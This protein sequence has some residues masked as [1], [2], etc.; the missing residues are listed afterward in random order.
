MATTCLTC[1]DEGIGSGL[2]GP[3][4]G[5]PC[6]P[7]GS[8]HPSCS[9]SSFYLVWLWQ[10]RGPVEPPWLPLSL[11]SSFI[12]KQEI[13]TVKAKLAV[14]VPCPHWGKPEAIVSQ[15]PLKDH[16]DIFQFTTSRLWSASNPGNSKIVICNSQDPWNYVNKCIKISYEAFQMYA[17]VSMG[18]WYRGHGWWEWETQ[19]K[20]KGTMV[21]GQEYLS[22]EAIPKSSM[23]IKMADA[24]WYI[25]ASFSIYV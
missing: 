15:C 5:E 8:P 23:W 2:P 20:Q 22:S 10:V 4:Y 21:S 17:S 11:W 6:W 1:A 9:A 12:F 19:P 24:V 13:L 7:T 14:L 18:P 3:W 25:V 16:D